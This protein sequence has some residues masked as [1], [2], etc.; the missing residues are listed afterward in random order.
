ML[1]T[2]ENKLQQNRYFLIAISILVLL[3]AISTSL[4]R[5]IPAF[6]AEEDLTTLSASAVSAYRW[7]EMAKFY[8]SQ[9]VHIPVTGEDLTAVNSADSSAYRWQEMAQFYI[10]QAS[11]KVKYGPPGR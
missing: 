2:S 5:D 11:T 10:R 4:W 8:S 6:S 3:L 7:N 1:S 9:L